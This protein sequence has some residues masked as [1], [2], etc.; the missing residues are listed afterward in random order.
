MCRVNKVPLAPLETMV[1]REPMVHQAH[2]ANREPTVAPETRDT[3]DQP[4][5]QDRL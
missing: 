2:P 5:P 4:D 1:S 3:Q